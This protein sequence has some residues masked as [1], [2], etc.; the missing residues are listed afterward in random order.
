MGWEL[1]NQ[2]SKS[3]PLAW[4]S[5]Q[6]CIARVTL[7]VPACQPGWEEIENLRGNFILSHIYPSIHTFC[8]LLC[9][10]KECWRV[11]TINILWISSRSG[12][13]HIIQQPIEA[14]QTRQWKGENIEW[15]DMFAF[16][17]KNKIADSW[18]LVGKCS[19]ANAR[20]LSKWGEQVTQLRALPKRR[21]YFYKGCSKSEAENQERAQIKSHKQT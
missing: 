18:N 2:A 21:V 1:A 19:T 7:I 6:N 20:I 4:S 5:Y 17:C 8:W 14:K 15:Q 9:S 3:Y 11:S 10:T 13:W 16:R 12:T